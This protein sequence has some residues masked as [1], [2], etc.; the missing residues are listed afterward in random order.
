[1]ISATSNA[2]GWTARTPLL[3]HQAEAVAKLLPARVG[4][5]LMEMGTGKSRVA[6]ELARLRQAKIDRVVW[7]CPVSTKE[8]IRREV[9][10]H[11]DCAA[12]DIHVFDE[13]T[14]AESLPAAFWHIVGL[15]SIGSSSRVALAL[16]ALITAS[17]LV[18]CDESQYIKGHRAKRTERLTFFAQRARYRLILSGTPLSQ[19]VVDLYA[20]MRFLSPNILGYASF[21]SFAANHLEYSE[22]FKG[23]IVRAHN[24]DYLA[25]KIRPYVYQVTKAECLSLPAKRYETRYFR[26]TTEQRGA[27]DWAKDFFLSNVEDFDSIAIFRLFTALQQITCGFLNW[28]REGG[29]PMERREFPHCRLDA[30]EDAVERVPEGAKIIV[31]AKYLR[32][33]EGISGL[34][35]KRFGAESFAE[36]HGGV[37]EA[38]RVRE[39]DRFRR[40]ARFLLAT[41]GCGGVGQTLNEAHHAIFYNNGFKWAQR[42]QAE[43]RF[44]RIG[45]GH[46]CTYIDLHCSDSIDDRIA[47]ALASKGDTVRRFKAEVDKVKKTRKQKLAEL[48]KSL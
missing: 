44:H 4:G 18:I 21:Y 23:M 45:Q 41:Q 16:N 37:N 31:W 30:F 29:G 6:V 12:A 26:M 13:D 5:A 22:K 28:R 7:C 38:R 48:V 17:T 39:L 34:L 47:K 32:D 15:E 1:M 27:Y 10:K 19:G 42:E 33:I 20:Q 25:A 40:E 14:R 8:T 43:D 9:L 2:A 35:R 24:V 11:T 36:F 46:D 3:P